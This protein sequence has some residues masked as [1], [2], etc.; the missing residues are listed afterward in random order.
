MVVAA[1]SVVTMSVPDGVVVGGVPARILSQFSDFENRLLG[2]WVSQTELDRCSGNYREK[3]LN[4]VESK[5]RPE[6]KK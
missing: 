5:M 3:I 2:G 4:V 6:M 1:G